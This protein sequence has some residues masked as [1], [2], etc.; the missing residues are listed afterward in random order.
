M[1]MRQG[2][3]CTGK[4][5]NVQNNS[6]S[7]KTQGNWKFCQNTGNF[8]CSSSK[9]HDSRYETLYIAIFALKITTFSQKLDKSI[10]SVLVTNHKHWQ[11]ENLQ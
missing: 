4:T 1:T 3:H 7:W 10:K 6:L 5:E 11:R 9:F 8:V 2:P